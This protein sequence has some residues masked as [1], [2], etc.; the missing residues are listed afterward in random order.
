M[1]PEDQLP[2]GWRVLPVRRVLQKL[3]RTPSDTG[4]VT[5]YRDGQVTLRSMRRADGYTMSEAEAGYQGVQVGDL[6]F[7]GLDGF[8]GA[9][10]IAEA[11]G[12][13]SPVYHVCA[14]RGEGDARFFAAALRAM[15]L[16]GYLELQSGTVRQRSVDFRAWPAFGRIPVVFPAP[17]VQ[18]EIADHLELGLAELDK[19]IA[20]RARSIDLLAE[21]E[22]SII[23]SM[24]KAADGE[25]RPVSSLGKYINGHPFKPGDFTGAG[26]P[27]VRIR[28]LVDET[29]S[30]DYFDAAVPDRVLLHDGDVVFSWSTT[31]A[32]RIW[33]RGPAILN[34]H[35]FRVVPA[36][37]VDSRWL[38]WALHAAARDFE[39][40]THGST[41]THITKPMMKLVTVP[42][43]SIHR[44]RDLA[45]DAD[46]VHNATD[47]VATKLRAQVNLLRERRDALLLAAVTGSIDPKSI[48]A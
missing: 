41:M 48:A 42:V 9:V 1:L 12:Q 22:M 31:L 15:G 40:F 8:A 25:S 44:Q 26:L 10:G 16:N 7:H 24:I 43:P 29:A 20:S 6:V 2:A 13:C 14:V 17:Q 35:L 21:R 32:A 18:T 37:G 45:R 30:F 3:A 4:V 11:S 23:Y 39:E 47:L 46:A 19:T 5:A 28:Q 38:R 34:Q 27:I 36:P 33:T